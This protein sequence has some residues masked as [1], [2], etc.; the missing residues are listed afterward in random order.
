VWS[1]DWLLEGAFL[2]Y[3]SLGVYK[4]ERLSQNC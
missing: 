4:S 1:K 3:H 2:S